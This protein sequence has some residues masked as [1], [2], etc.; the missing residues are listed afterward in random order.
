MC[1]NL[2]QLKK[3]LAEK[4]WFRAGERGEERRVIRALNERAL[5]VGDRKE[6]VL[7]WLHWNRALMGI[8]AEARTAIAGRVLAFGDERELTSLGLDKSKIVSEFDSLSERISAVVPLTAAG[9]R[10]DVT[11]LTSKALWGCYPDDVPICDNN[12]KCALGVIS[13]LCHWAPTPSK[14]EYA[15]FVDVWFRVYEEIEPVIDEADLSDCP[16]KVR[17]IDSMLWYLGQGGFY[18]GGA[19]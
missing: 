7:R 10:R 18:S 1:P 2:R 12:A 14:S 8:S 13:R 19:T 5:G 15:P 11:S 6:S 17:V 16:H 3:E 9:G 4:R